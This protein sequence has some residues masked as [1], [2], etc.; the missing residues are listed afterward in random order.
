MKSTVDELKMEMK[1]LRANN[2]NMMN[3]SGN[4][5]IDNLSNNNNNSEKNYDQCRKKFRY[6]LRKIAKFFRFEYNFTV[7]NILFP[8]IWQRDPLKTNPDYWKIKDD[9]DFR[10]IRI[11]KSVVNFVLD[12]KRFKDEKYGF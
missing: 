8:L 4:S 11:L 1:K 10:C 7:D 5:Y 6:N 12:T 9:N 2:D 3:G